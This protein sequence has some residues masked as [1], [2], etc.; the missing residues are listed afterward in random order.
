[1]TLGLRGSGIADED[2]KGLGASSDE[3]VLDGAVI[4]AMGSGMEL[5]VLRGES[6]VDG[7]NEEVVVLNGKSEFTG[8]NEEV[9]AELMGVNP[10]A[11]TVLFPTLVGVLISVKFPPEVSPFHCPL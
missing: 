8:S 6:D 11:P 9:V 3:F 10:S 2:G 7:S 5:V 4:V 1:M